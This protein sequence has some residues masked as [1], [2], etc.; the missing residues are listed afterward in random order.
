MAP[1]Q[2]LRQQI[3]N[4]SLLF[5]Y[6]PRKDDRLSWPGWLTCSGWFTHLSGHPSATGRAWD[7]KS[8]PA[9]DQCSTAGPH[10]QPRVRLPI[11]LRSVGR[12]GKNEATGWFRVSA[13]SSLQ[14]FDAVAHPV[15]KKDLLQSSISG[16]PAKP[17]VVPDKYITVLCITLLD[18]WTYSGFGQTSLKQTFWICAAGFYRPD[19]L[20]ATQP[21]ESKRRREIR[22]EFFF[23][24]IVP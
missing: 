20:P 7:S 18:F 23:Y 5:I 8:T 21:T 19:D 11:P 17:G 3:S 1:P 6:R 12:S 16:D 10:N 15:C 2:Q 9:K 4:C 13:L 22:W 24:T 14:C